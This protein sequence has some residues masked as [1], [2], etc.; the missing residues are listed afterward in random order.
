MRE[1]PF[2]HNHNVTLVAVS[3]RGKRIESSPRDVTL[4]A[5]DTLLL[6]MGSNKAQPQ[7]FSK[8]LQFFDSVEVPNIGMGTLVSTAIMIT[9][10]MMLL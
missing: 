1:S 2:E 3:R 9:M 10:P 5:G 8:D 6:E 4:Q 7:E